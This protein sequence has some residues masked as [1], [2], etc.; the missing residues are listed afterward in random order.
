MII[1]LFTELNKYDNLDFLS[2]NGKFLFLEKD[3][4][5]REIF[6]TKMNNCYLTGLSMYYPNILIY[7]HYSDFYILPVNQHVK[8]NFLKKV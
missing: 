2:K 7:S 4:N 3:E 5:Q 1:K 8:P 6:I